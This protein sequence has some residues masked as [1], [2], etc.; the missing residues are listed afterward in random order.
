MQLGLTEEETMVL[1]NLLTETIEADRYPFLGPLIEHW[2]CY[3]RYP[4]TRCITLFQSDQQIS[5]PAPRMLSLGYVAAA[6]GDQER[7]SKE[8][9]R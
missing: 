6:G 1:L 4:E 2:L 5:P 7:A 3:R 9:K 8:A